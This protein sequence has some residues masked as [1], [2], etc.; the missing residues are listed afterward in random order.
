M[1]HPDIAIRRALVSEAAQ[2]TDLAMRSKAM[3]GYDERFMAQCVDELTIEKTAIAAGNVW[4]AETDGAIV[5]L[6]EL[7]LEGRSVELRMI[8]VEPVWVRSGVGR[9]LWAHA[10]AHALAF[11]AETLELDADPNAMPFYERMGM[12][13][14]GESP[15]GSI[16][17]RTLPRMAKH[18]GAGSHGR[19]A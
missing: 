1:V 16:P 13:Q 11:G 12:R 3:W 9:V 15:S 6:L 2:L 14:I 4:V 17:G 8:F 10:E 19:A 18:L 7:I 5:G